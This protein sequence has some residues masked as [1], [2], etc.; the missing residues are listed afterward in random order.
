MVPDQWEPGEAKQIKAGSDIVF[1]M[2]YTANGKAGADQTRIGLVFCKVPPTK[3]IITIGALNNVFKIPAGDANFKAE[4]TV[5][6]A[7]PMTVVSLFPHMHLRGKAFQYDVIYPT[8]RPKRS[9]RW[10]IGASTGSFRISS[11]SRWSCSRAPRSRQRRGG[12]IP[13]TIPRIPILPRS[14]S[15]ASRAGKR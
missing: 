15:G 8:A 10:T 1:Q 9:S 2:H 14:Y 11:P 7:N 6:V 3:R 12:I 5:P 4:A 13:P